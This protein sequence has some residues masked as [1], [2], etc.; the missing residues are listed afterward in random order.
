MTNVEMRFEYFKC[1]EIKLFAVGEIACIDSGSFPSRKALH[2]ALPKRHG[3][4]EKEPS[5]DFVTVCVN[6]L[7]CAINNDFGSL[8]FPALGVDSVH[9]ISGSVAAN[10]LLYCIDK[11]YYQKKDATLHTIRIVIT[12][13]LSSTFL[14]CFDEHPFEA[15][16]NQ[17][18]PC[19]SA[20][21]ISASCPPKYEWYWEDDKTQFTQYS[22]TVSDALTA[23]KLENPD[24]RCY[25]RISG[26]PTLW[27]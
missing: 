13:D 1:S 18:K 20:A 21:G 3:M 5:V 4:E 15:A 9:N 8:S 7:D 19:S 22:Q 10:T 6:A 17:S 11:H 2:V 12:Q 23:A 24:K 27:I 26:K 14:S 16:V 25:I